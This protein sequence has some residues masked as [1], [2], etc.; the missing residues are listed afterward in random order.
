MRDSLISF[1]KHNGSPV[2]V[3]LLTVD[4]LRDEDGQWV[5]T[6]LELGTV[7]CAESLEQVREEVRDALEL[8]L[9]GMAEL[10]YITEYLKEMGV[11][12]FLVPT[13]AKPPHAV[14]LDPTKSRWEM[15]SAAV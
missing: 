15:A 11:S 3:A 1:L 12:C 8:Q 5:A 2:M 6:C 13:R 7:A 9:N 14:H 4:F 10:G